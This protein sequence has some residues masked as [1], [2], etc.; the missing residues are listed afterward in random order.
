MQIGK[1]IFVELSK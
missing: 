1:V